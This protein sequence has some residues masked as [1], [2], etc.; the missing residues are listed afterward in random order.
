MRTLIDVGA[1]EYSGKIRIV[2]VDGR[3]FVGEADVTTMS[4]D[5]EELG[6]ENPSDWPSVLVDG[7]LI[8]FRADEITTIEKIA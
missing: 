1:Y 3:V 5:E 4:E 6:I 2:L 7:M 8:D